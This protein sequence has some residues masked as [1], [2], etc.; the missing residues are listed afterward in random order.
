[1]SIAEKVDD[2]PEDDAV[3]LVSSLEEDEFAELVLD[4]PLA[5]GGGGGGGGAFASRKDDNSDCDT[6]PSPSVSIDD[7]RSDAMLD[8]VEDALVVEDESE[9]SAAPPSRGG[10]GGGMFACMKP[11][12]SLSEIAPSPSVSMASKAC[13]DDELADD[14]AE[15]P[16]LEVAPSCTE[17]NAPRVSFDMVSTKLCN[18]LDDSPPDPSESMDEKSCDSLSLALVEEVST[19][20]DALA[21]V[22]RGG[23]R[24][25]RWTED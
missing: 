12:S 10:G 16:S 23:G 1:M 11:E 17:S 19:P 7:I 22:V 9:A 18:S 3:P 24:S 14:V 15:V 5:S 6:E 20:P 8:E 4:D 21:P 13:A 25:I 2:E